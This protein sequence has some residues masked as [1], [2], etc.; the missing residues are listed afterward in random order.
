[1]GHTLDAAPRAHPTSPRRRARALAALAGLA[2]AAPLLGGC[3]ATTAGAKYTWYGDYVDAEPAGAPYLIAPG[4]L[5]SVKVFGQEAM[6]SKVRVRSDGMVSLPFVND[7]K[8]AGQT[9]VAFAAR[10]KGLL[11]EFVVNPV[12]TVS[13]EEARPFEISVVGEVT[14]PGVYK[15]EPRA[16]VLHALAAA[17]GL[18][19]FANR[20]RIFVL[21]G[22]MR[23]RFTFKALTE[24][25]PGAA[26]FWLRPGD[27]VV[28]E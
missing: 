4:D 8:A 16:S 15:L 17:G 21:R 1:M 18:G 13:L 14:K 26:N 6:S 27:I 25:L 11:K 10:V 28:V 12:V 24:A 9:P 2:L 23:V 3:E 5:I 19:D 7:V 22:G 20:E